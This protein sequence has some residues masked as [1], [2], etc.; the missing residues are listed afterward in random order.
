MA[1]HDAHTECAVISQLINFPEAWDGVSD[2]IESELFTDETCRNVFL[3]VKRLNDKGESADAVAIIRKMDGVVSMDDFMFLKNFYDHSARGLQRSVKALGEL[4]MA[5]KLHMASHKIAELAQ[6]SEQG[7]IANRLESAK[8]CLDEL[9]F[10]QDEVEYKDAFTIA[11]EHQELLDARDRGT[12][13]VYKTGFIDLDD[14]LGGG[15]EPGKLMIIGARP[16]VGKS[17]IAL[18]IGLSMATVHPTAFMSMEMPYSDVAD[19]QFAILGKVKMQQLRQPKQG[20]EWERVVDAAERSKATKFFVTDKTSLNI[21]GVRSFAR[22]MKR[23]HDLHVLVI[24]YIGLMKGTNPKLDKR[25]QIEEITQGLKNLAKELGIAII[26]LAQLNRD[27]DAHPL[28]IPGLKNLAD[29]A[30]IERDADIIGFLHRPIVVNP[31]LGDKFKNFAVLRIAK[32]RQGVTGDVNFFYQG[33]V[34][35]FESWGGQSPIAE[36]KS[37]TPAKQKRGMNE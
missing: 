25:F 2:S 34:M 31:D 29:S 19:R 4:S 37:Q 16:S 18:N 10:K 9:E 8:A 30:S 22:R 24:D 7:D 14:L 36:A 17:A 28:D 1:M 11:M 3:I 20:L 15:L 13:I 32:N 26:A 27:A 6:D 12:S 23:K 33:E 21:N 35:G 5:R